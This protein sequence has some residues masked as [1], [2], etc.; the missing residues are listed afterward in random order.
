M[1]CPDKGDM[2]GMSVKTLKE[3][4]KRRDL[5]MTGMKAGLIQR[6]IDPRAQTRGEKERVVK[7]IYE[8]QREINTRHAEQRS[9]CMVRVAERH[10]TVS[11]LFH[12]NDDDADWITMLP[13]KRSCPR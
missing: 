11:F 10:R 3:M 9:S 1:A 7:R 12:A 4:R 13:S 5:T 2:L 8:L 6:L